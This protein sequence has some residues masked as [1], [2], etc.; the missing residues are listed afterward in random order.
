MRQHQLAPLVDN[1]VFG[2]GPRWHQDAL[3]FSDIK[4]HCVN[5][6][7]SDGKIEKIVEIDGEPSGLGWLPSGELLIVS[8]LEHSLLRYDNNKLSLVANFSEHCGGKANDMVVDQYGH[9]FIGNLGF[10]IEAEPMVPAATQVV[11]VDIDGSVHIAATDIWCPNGMG[12]T[13]DGKTLLVSQSASTEMLGFDLAAD[14]GLSNRHVYTT[15]PDGAT[16]DGIC[17]DSEAAIWA[18]NPVGHEFLRALP[19]GEIT[20]RI[21]TGNMQAIACML[22]GKDRKTLYCITNETNS[23]DIAEQQRGG[24][25]STAR[26]DVAGAG[27]P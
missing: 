27:W 9:A 16:Y 22:G 25:I 15:L 17:V 8:M 11:R 2:E 10:D 19:G 20:D 24:M 3:W 7:T 5:R 4:D 21:D 23:L 12:I 18:A 14:G 6:L 1:I 13:P 26:V